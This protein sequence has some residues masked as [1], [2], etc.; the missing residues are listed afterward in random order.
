[1][2]GPGERG[3]LTCEIGRACGALERS[4][5]CPLIHSGR[6]RIADDRL[7]I[8]SAALAHPRRLHRPAP[9]PHGGDARRRRSLRAAR[10]HDDLQRASATVRCTRSRRT[11]ASRPAPPAGPARRA[12]RSRGRARR[13]SSVR[14]AAP[15]RSSSR[16]ARRRPRPP[17]AWSVGSRASA[18]SPARR[19]PAQGAVNVEVLHATGKITVG[20]PIRT[21][22][23]WGAT[24]SVK[25]VEG[26]FKVQAGESTTVRLKFTASG[27]PVRIDDVYIDPRLRGG[28]ASR[29]A[30]GEL[31]SCR[32]IG[33]HDRCRLRPSSSSRTILSS[34]PSWPT[35]SRR[36]ATS[37]C[38]PRRSGTGCASSS[39][40]ARTSWSSISGCPTARGST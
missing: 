33:W 26:Q 37:R 1:M 17:S 13:S 23:V 39:S 28:L 11:A 24:G 35:T 29:P 9:L 19:A 38:S 30:G 8:K 34:A 40:G 22:A 25:L 27:G 31:W 4:D 7:V 16:R 12:R 3:S 32:P 15:S 10:V 18:S 20:G 14:P 36:T 5:V 2:G 6:P 21:T